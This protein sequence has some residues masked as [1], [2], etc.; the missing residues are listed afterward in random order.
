[1]SLSSRA[2]LRTSAGVSRG[3]SMSYWSLRRVDDDVRFTGA[4]VDGNP[5]DVEPF[6]L[7]LLIP[8]V[9]EGGV[10]DHDDPFLHG[11]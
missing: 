10:L 3:I 8:E 6:F 2:T 4:H 7:K 11:R 9:L 5:L 1:M